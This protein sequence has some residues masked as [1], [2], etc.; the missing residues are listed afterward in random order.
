LPKQ[1]SSANQRLE[2]SSRC[3]TALFVE[4]CSA[5]ED[6]FVGGNAA[7]NSSEDFAKS[8]MTFVVEDDWPADSPTG[9]ARD[10][11]LG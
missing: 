8:F 1:H 5:N 4:S 7:T 3:V 6:D 10:L 2:N 9:A 11:R